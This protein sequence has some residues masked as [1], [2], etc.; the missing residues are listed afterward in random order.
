[1]NYFAWKKVMRV[2]LR[3]AGLLGIVDHSEPRPSS[4]EGR[5]AI[6]RWEAK[7]RSAKTQLVMN[8]EMALYNQLEEDELQPAYC[9]WEE[10]STCFEQNSAMA[11]AG[12]SQ[13]LRTRPIKLGESM[14]S[15]IQALHELREELT[16]LGGKIDDD[17]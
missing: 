17:E 15:H 11:R 9:L 1:M 5:S 7:D 8:I 4:M 3:N 13:R 2:C 10:V 6:E 14:F 16:N 12:A